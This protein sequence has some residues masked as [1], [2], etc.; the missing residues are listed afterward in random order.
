MDVGGGRDGREWWM[1]VGVREGWVSGSG[2][3]KVGGGERRRNE[4]A[5]GAELHEV[6]FAD[7][8]VN[9]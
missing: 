4:A 9:E 2:V 3:W 8:V 7:P 5:V 1:W 6:G